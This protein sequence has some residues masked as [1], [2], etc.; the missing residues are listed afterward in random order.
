MGRQ[1]KIICFV[2]L[3]CEETFNLVLRPWYLYSENCAAKAL[4]LRLRQLHMPND[5]AVP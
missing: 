1:S 3:F 2:N 4:L 5:K